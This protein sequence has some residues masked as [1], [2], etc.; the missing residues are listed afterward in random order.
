MEERNNSRSKQLR[1]PQFINKEQVMD[2]TRQ[3]PVLRTL[4]LACNRQYEDREIT[5]CPND[6]TLLVNVS[7]APTEAWL[8]RV[9]ESKYK[10]VQTIGRDKF[11]AEQTSDGST[12]EILLME[13][14]LRF[15]DTIQSWKM[16]THPNILKLHDYGRID[17]GQCY[18]A[19]EPFTNGTGLESILKQ[20]GSLP[21][22][23]CLR[24]LSQAMDAVKTIHSA[25][26]VHRDLN[27]YTILVAED[28][29]DMVKVSELGISQARPPAPLD[30]P[31]DFRAESLRFNYVS[32]EQ[33]RGQK[34]DPRSDIYSLAT[35]LYE[36]LTGLPPFPADS[37]IKTATLHISACP[38]PFGVVR[39]DLRLSNR[40][41]AVVF[42]ALEKSPSDRY[43]SID[44]FQQAL[45]EAIAGPES[46]DGYLNVDE[47]PDLSI[48]TKSPSIVAQSGQSKSNGQTSITS[49]I[50]IILF[51]ACIL[52]ALLLFLVQRHSGNPGP[53]TTTSPI[54]DTIAGSVEE[55][56]VPVQ[57]ARMK[58]TEGLVSAIALEPPTATSANEAVQHQSMP[59]CHI[60]LFSSS[61]NLVKLDA[62]FAITPEAP[63]PKIGDICRIAVANNVAI[64]FIII[65]ENSNIKRCSKLVLDFIAAVD[66]E[67]WS[68]A[69]QLFATSNP[70]RIS[71]LRRS[72]SDAKFSIGK[73][74]KNAEQALP[75][76]L[77][78]LSVSPAKIE[79][80]LNESLLFAKQNAIDKFTFVPTDSDSKEWK[81]S[82]IEQRVS[83]RLWH[84]K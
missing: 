16:L 55:D 52:S 39:P 36:C 77:K 44:E 78:V 38:T 60:S 82:S 19:V 83:R 18:F 28:R 81:L 68:Q 30:K 42:K 33:C 26:L 40:L 29:Q 80:L 20:C 53:N 9:I 45:T 74:G 11:R 5:H 69:D 67:Q 73:T 7:P 79:I 32:P 17:D 56:P 41:Q 57:G 13:H 84:D 21:P 47:K 31:R 43:Q 54:S 3:R 10:I 24:I 70:N 4:C 64:Q 15:N 2:S 61:G 23:R 12:V 8:D 25:G 58:T 22:V 14:G 71:K 1:K 37:Y 63:P 46:H 62:N 48:K 6:N 51:N 59:T 34:L 50:K 65:G 49:R 27:P 76:A 72:W 35:V 75:Q 66:K